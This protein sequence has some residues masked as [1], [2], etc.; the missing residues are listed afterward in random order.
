MNLGPQDKLFIFT[1]GHGEW[2]DPFQGSVLNLWD[3]NNLSS[4]DLK[5]K[6]GGFPNIGN[7][8]VV[9]SQCSSGGFISGVPDW[10]PEVYS[11]TGPNRTIITSVAWNEPAR[12]ELFITLSNEDPGP[13]YPLYGPTSVGLGYDEFVYYWTSA[14]RGYY[15]ARAQVQIGGATHWKNKPWLTSYAVGSFSFSTI[16]GFGSTAIYPH[17][18]DYIPQRINGL[19][20]LFGSYQY[21]NNWDTTTGPGADNENYW[22]PSTP[23]TWPEENFYN[24]HL[25]PQYWSNGELFEKLQTITGVDLNISDNLFLFGK[26]DLYNKVLNCSGDLYLE[27]E[28]AI[29]QLHSN[30][31]LNI[32]SGGSVS[33]T[34]GELNTENSHVNVRGSL[35]L[36][37]WV[38]FL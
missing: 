37:Q 30:A 4:V 12:A 3:N 29:L 26:T 14:I 2:L 10:D 21:A 11:I 19:S 20:T 38:L 35:Y 6:L 34:S 8:T 16:E 24:L 17:P 32:L 36:T 7:I 1:T 28:H 33:V 23:Q 9:M 18:N 25:H 22:N 31:T 27:D 5:N 15:P 13:G